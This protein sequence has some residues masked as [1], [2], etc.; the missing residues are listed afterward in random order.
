[1]K[2]RSTGIIAFL[3]GIAAFLAGGIAFANSQH[4][5]D[6][7]SART[8]Q[9]LIDHATQVQ[10][11]KEG[12]AAWQKAFDYTGEDNSSDKSFYQGIQ[13]CGLLLLGAGAVMVFLGKRP[14]NALEV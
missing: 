1:M 12:P 3:A 5:A 13:L 9:A 2:L 8:R 14:K 10:G 11:S 7:R 6:A 4:E